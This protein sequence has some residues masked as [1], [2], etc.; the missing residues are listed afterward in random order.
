MQTAKRHQSPCIVL[1]S[2]PVHKSGDVCSDRAWRI[3]RNA[4]GTEGTAGTD[5]CITGTSPPNPRHACTWTRGTCIPKVWHRSLDARKT[6]VWWG[7]NF[8]SRCVYLVTAV[9]MTFMNTIIQEFLF[10]FF[11]VP[12]RCPVAV[13]A[14]TTSPAVS[15]SSTGKEDLAHCYMHTHWMEL[16]VQFPGCWLLC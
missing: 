13:T 15:T 3:S 10:P 4:G 1:Q 9:S 2:P 16:P 12:W 8:T 7:K 5:V 11:H 14:P 6:N